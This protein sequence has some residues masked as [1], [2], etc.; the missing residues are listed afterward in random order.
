MMPGEKTQAV[1]MSVFA[2]L[3]QRGFRGTAIIV[4]AVR[5]HLATKKMPELPKK[6]QT[7]E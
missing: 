4:E 7:T 1:L 2:T 5:E 6:L 3:K